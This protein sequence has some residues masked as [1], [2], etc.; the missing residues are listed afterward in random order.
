MLRYLGKRKVAEVFDR[1]S[2]YWALPSAQHSLVRKR[3]K[4]P[5]LSLCVPALILMSHG[6]EPSVPCVALPSVAA[7]SAVAA[8]IAAL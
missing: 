2:K 4:E 5:E 8:S 7:V 6:F 1:G 3:R